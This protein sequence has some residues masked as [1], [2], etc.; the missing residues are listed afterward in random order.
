MKPKA[1]PSSAQPDFFQGELSSIISLRHP[2]GGGSVCPLLFPL[3]EEEKR[4]CRVCILGE[5]GTI[6]ADTRGPPLSGSLPL[7]HNRQ[8]W[9]DPKSAESVC[10]LRFHAA[11]HCPPNAAKKTTLKV[12]VM[13]LAPAV[14]TFLIL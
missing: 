9:A 6:L 8:H 3:D 11:R 10:P 5:D 7:A 2:L 4:H 1:T 12:L 14:L 13:G